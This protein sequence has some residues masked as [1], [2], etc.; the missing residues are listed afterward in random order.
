MD[1]E[2]IYSAFEDDEMNPPLITICAEL[3]KQGYDVKVEGVEFTNSDICF[4]LLS[5]LERVTNEISVEIT[6]ENITKRFKLVFTDYHRFEL[7]E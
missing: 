3:V 4:S 7:K 1:L 2:K 5:D 6:S